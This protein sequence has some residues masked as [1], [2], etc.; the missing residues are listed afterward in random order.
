MAKFCLSFRDSILDGTPYH[1]N[2]PVEFAELEVRGISLGAF[3]PGEL[4]RKAL[5]LHL[6]SWR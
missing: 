3:G 1:A 2:H 5:G 4:C 6:E